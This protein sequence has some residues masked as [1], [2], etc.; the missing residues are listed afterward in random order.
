MNWS[1]EDLDRL[2][3]AIMDGGRVQINRRGTE[4]VLIPHAL[5]TEGTAETVVGRHPTTGDDMEFRLDEI[6]HFVVV[7]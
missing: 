6:D 2:E 5:R 7:D 4:Y 1:P 3:R